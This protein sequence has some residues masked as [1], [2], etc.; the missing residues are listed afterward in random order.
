VL[1]EPDGRARLTDFGSARLDGQLGVTGTGA[2]AGTLAYTSPEI[3]AG[4]RGDARADV[5][6]LGLSLYFALTGNLPDSPS[7]HLPPTPQES[8]Y[9]PR[10]V[11][12][13][14]PQ[15]L[16]EVIARATTSAAENRFPTAAAFGEA[17]AGGG[18][19]PAL[20]RDEAGACL[21]C[22]GPDPLTLGI[23][24]PCGG[25]PD[26]ADTLVFLDAA[27]TISGRRAAA[28]RLA[29]VLPDLRDA[30][31]EAAARGERPLFRV[32]GTSAPK[33]LEELERRE[34]PSRAMLPSRAWAAVPTGFWMLLAAVVVA[35]GT[36]G[37]AVAPTLLATTPMVGTLLVL[38]ARRASRTPLVVPPPRKSGL[39]SAVE[40]DVVRTLAEL[41]PG[42]ARSLLSDL[43][44]MCAALGARLE[45]TGDDRGLMPQLA[46]LLGAA[47]AAATDLSQLDENLG[48][49][50]RQRDRLAVLPEGWLD[51][52][53]R[54]ERTRDAL[55]QR[56]LEAMTVAG[57]LQGQQAA[58]AAATD[59]SLADLTREL[60]QEGDAQGA[61]AREVAALFGTE[62]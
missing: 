44:R 26:V 19:S 49:F 24:P 21:L 22:G 57:R 32:A 55:V 15:W 38:G 13:G 62:G 1:L 61:A 42:T 27:G 41:P 9:H 2:L 25:S 29:V 34:L 23:C 6:A 50:E 5:Y 53:A 4:R 36:A 30:D 20:S 7:P 46:E 51:T 43:V 39:P 28:L 54:C 11:S 16:D 8:G 14:V 3:L 45:R 18:A 56:L 17:L 12:P 52:L 60:R 58:F 47:C 10:L 33:L 35:G 37:L 59:D 48:P 31:R 40:N